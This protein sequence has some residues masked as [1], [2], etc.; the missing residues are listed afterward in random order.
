MGIIDFISQLFKRKEKQAL[1]KPEEANKI[2]EELRKFGK[3]IE[4]EVNIDELIINSENIKQLPK[5]KTRF[6]REQIVNIATKFYESL[7]I[8]ENINI[9]TTVKHGDINYL[10]QAVNRVAQ[11]LSKIET[12]DE[13]SKVIPKCM[14]KIFENYLKSLSDNEC[15]EL[16]INKE[17]IKH[18]V[19]LRNITETLKLKK[20][21]INTN[22]I[23]IKHIWGKFY[24][25]K[26]D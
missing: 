3:E 15:R 11:R 9:D 6:S 8:K 24:A 18:D 2:F 20:D 12:S 4:T 23:N 14:E 13:Y 26:F 1:P 21:L 7:G 22:P 25:T 10:F 16:K 5:L 19:I 17:E